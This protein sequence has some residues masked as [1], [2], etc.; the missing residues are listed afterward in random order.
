MRIVYTR[1]ASAMLEERAIDRAWIELTIF[2]PTRPS[3]IAGT[4]R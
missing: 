4:K 3:R 1:H 2:F